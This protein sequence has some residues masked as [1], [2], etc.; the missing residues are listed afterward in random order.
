MIAI[1]TTIMAMRTNAGK[2]GPSACALKHSRPDPQVTAA[3]VSFFASSFQPFSWQFAAKN[4]FLFFAAGIEFVHGFDDSLL[5][6]E[7]HRLGRRFQG[8]FDFW[9]LLGGKCGQHVILLRHHARRVDADPQAAVILTAL[10]CHRGKSPDRLFN[11]AQAVV[12]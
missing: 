11:V 6:P 7:R 12:P 4:S 8:G 5:G 10:S 2:N 3:R 9:L 1:M